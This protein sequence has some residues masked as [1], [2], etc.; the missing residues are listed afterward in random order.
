MTGI[1]D[2][3]ATFD[4]EN[5]RNFQSL[6]RYHGDKTRWVLDAWAKTWLSPAFAHWSLAQVLPTIHCPTLALQGVDD[7]YNTTAH[8]QTIAEQVAGHA[9]LELMPNTGHF[10]HK[11]HPEAVLAV[12][13]AFLHDING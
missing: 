5:A 12:I 1:R 13:V 2:N 9:S 4:N 3:Y 7:E 11:Q 6:T 10:P 8:S